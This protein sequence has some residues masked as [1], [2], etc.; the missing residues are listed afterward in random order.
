MSYL[1]VQGQ[2]KVGSQYEVGATEKKDLSAS[3]RLSN[4]SNINHADK[5]DF[6]VAVGRGREFAARGLEFLKGA[7][8]STLGHLSYALGACLGGKTKLNEENKEDSGRQI[9]NMFQRIG[10]E[11]IAAGKEM[12]ASKQEQKGPLVRIP[13]ED[14]KDS[15][16]ATHLLNARGMANKNAIPVVHL[17]TQEKFQAAIDILNSAVKAE[18]DPIAKKE[19]QNQIIKIEAEKQDHFE[20]KLKGK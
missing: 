5:N 3:D 19:I 17:Q 6:Q 4:Q 11:A 15:Q 18:Q 13:L 8:V 16:A 14:I 20:A 2:S 12:R 1:N 7:S 9:G 10:K